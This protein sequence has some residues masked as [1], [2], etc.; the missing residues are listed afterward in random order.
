MAKA[1]QG[2]LRR[3]A[4]L[5]K[6]WAAKNAKDTCK[7][8]QSMSLGALRLKTRCYLEVLARLQE[9]VRRKRPK[10][11][12]DKLIP[13]HNNALAHDTLIVRKFPAKKSIAKWTIHLIH[14]TKPL[15]IFYSFQN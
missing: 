2:R 13:N 3:R 9:S 12:P 5:P 4:K 8:G 15:A 11:A 7:Y 14:L 6:K 10:L 1:V